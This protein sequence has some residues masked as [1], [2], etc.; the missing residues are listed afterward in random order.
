MADYLIS[1]QTGYTPEDGLTGQQLFGG[2][3]GL[4]YK[5]CPGTVIP[6][7]TPGSLCRGHGTGTGSTPVRVPVPG[8]YP[9]TRTHQVQSSGRLRNI[10]DAPEC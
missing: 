3:D 4:T 1:G 10:S 7:A 8:Q 9:A 2:G 5:P 6:G